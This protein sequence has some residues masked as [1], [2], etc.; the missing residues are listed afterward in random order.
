MFYDAYFFNDDFFSFNKLRTLKLL[1]SYFN[2]QDLEDL[3]NL[4][5]NLKH[6]KTVSISF[7]CLTEEDFEEFLSI[8]KE[9]EEENVVYEPQFSV[10]VVLMIKFVQILKMQKPPKASADGG[11][12]I[13]NLEK[14]RK[15]VPTNSHTT[16]VS[17]YGI[18]AE[19]QEDIANGVNCF[20][21]ISPTSR[22]NS[23][24]TAFFNYC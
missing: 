23:N 14:Q 17:L 18:C 3:L 11:F 19:L 5:V 9:P 4:F 24:D 6:L 2:N 20:I 13:G 7:F 8:L 1:D 10:I 16:K 21:Q 22:R 12:N 15:I